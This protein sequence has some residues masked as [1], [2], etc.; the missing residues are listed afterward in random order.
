MIGG[1][2]AISGR[3]PPT[4]SCGLR[5]KYARTRA[6]EPTDRYWIAFDGPV[7]CGSPT[8]PPPPPPPP[9]ARGGSPPRPPRAPPPLGPP[10]VRQG[11]LVVGEPPAAPATVE[12]SRAVLDPP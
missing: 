4:G 8:R 1:A 12:V 3:L 9:R 10:R 11:V 7:H 2:W 6:T 5:T